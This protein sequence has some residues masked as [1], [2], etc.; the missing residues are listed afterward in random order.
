MIEKEGCVALRKA[1]F[2]SNMQVKKL[3]NDAVLMQVNI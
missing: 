2:D 3:S 1:L